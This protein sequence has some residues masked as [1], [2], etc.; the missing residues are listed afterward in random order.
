[1]TLESHQRPHLFTLPSPKEV[2]GYSYVTQRLEDPDLSDTSPYKTKRLAHKTN[3]HC[4]RQAAAGITGIL[5][6]YGLIEYGSRINHEPASPLPSPTSLY[7]PEKEVS[8]QIRMKS[9]NPFAT[10]I[11][12]P[13]L[14]EPTAVLTPTEIMPTPTSL[15][16]VSDIEFRNLHPEQK[17]PQFRLGLISWEEVVII[18]VPKDTAL[19]IGYEE[20]IRVTIAPM[21]QFGSNTDPSD[22][23][24]FGDWQTYPH[25]MFVYRASLPD[26][27]NNNLIYGHAYEGETDYGYEEMPFEWLRKAVEMNVLTEDDKLYIVQATIGGEVQEEVRFIANIR[28]PVDTFINPGV[29]LDNVEDDDAMFIDPLSMDYA[30]ASGNNKI[31]LGTCTGND[32]GKNLQDRSHRAFA[33]FQL[34]Q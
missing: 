4:V 7:K 19:K 30:D 18:V 26:S 6:V 22:D 27:Q 28:V 15:P 32:L 2:D 11:P 10:R 3:W 1:M 13:V 12:T 25:N 8:A 23:T 34:I 24:K 29:F 9:A 31:T 5:A 20:E 21:P 17:N 16:E 33:T 14:P